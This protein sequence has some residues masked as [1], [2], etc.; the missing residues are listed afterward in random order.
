MAQL[1][2]YYQHHEDINGVVATNDLTVRYY[3]SMSLPQRRLTFTKNRLIMFTA[4]YYFTKRSPFKDLFDVRIQELNDAGLLSYYTKAY[5]SSRSKS[6]Q[7]SYSELKKDSLL[8]LFEICVIIYII[9]VFVFILEILS[10]K[11]RCIKGFIDFLTY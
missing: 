1:E 4:V 11:C 10:T 5:D 9:S 2:Y 7:S 3:N 6:N 8:A